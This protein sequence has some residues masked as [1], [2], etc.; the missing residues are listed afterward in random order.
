MQSFAHQTIFLV[1]PFKIRSLFLLTHE[2]TEMADKRRNRRQNQEKMS[3]F[4]F[5]LGNDE[6]SDE[7]SATDSELDITVN[8]PV[9]DADDISALPRTSNSPT[10]EVIS[11]QTNFI[12]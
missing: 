6:I 11:H 9:A 7:F 4:T 1:Y 10:L 3:Y 5:M 2:L 12:L 8:Q